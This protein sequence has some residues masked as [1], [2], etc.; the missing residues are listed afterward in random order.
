MNRAIHVM[1]VCA[2]VAAAARLV[3]QQPTFRTETEV[4]SFG[5]TVVDKRGHFIRDLQRED[6]E[7]IEEG[8]K[9]T[10]RIFARGD[11]VEAAPQMHVGLLF[12]LQWLAFRGS[13]RPS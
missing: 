7:I 4:V 9:Q 3:A 12:D 11:A 5:V 1:L 6:F 10:I 8:R 13:E 2:A